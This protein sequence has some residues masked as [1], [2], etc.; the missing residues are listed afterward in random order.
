[1][2]TR[3][4]GTHVAAVMVLLGGIA[5]GQVVSGPPGV[6][7][8]PGAPMLAFVTPQTGPTEPDKAYYYSTIGQE[9]TYASIREQEARRPDKAAPGTK[10]PARNEVPS[11]PLE[12]PGGVSPLSSA[13][14]PAVSALCPSPSR[15]MSR[16]EAAGCRL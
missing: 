16:L 4:V 2:S 7:L 10:P 14:R 6:P 3:I 5:A 11:S 15:L 9:L 12:A 1:M 8:G 13:F